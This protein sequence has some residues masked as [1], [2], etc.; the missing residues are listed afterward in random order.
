[1]GCSGRHL[2]GELLIKKAES[3]DSGQFVAE[4]TRWT[5]MVWQRQDPQ[6]ILDEELLV[7][8]GSYRFMKPRRTFLPR[9]R[10]L[11][12]DWDLQQEHHKSAFQSVYYS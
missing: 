10:P 5:E 9:G 11:H 4:F 12:V 7:G 6:Q 3:S 8:T 1:M 2:N